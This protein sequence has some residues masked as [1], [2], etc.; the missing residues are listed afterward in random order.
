M[1]IF[2]PCMF[3]L[4]L[5]MLCTKIFIGIILGLFG[6]CFLI[7]EENIEITVVHVVL[8]ILLLPITLIFFIFLGLKYVFNNE[9]VNQLKEIFFLPC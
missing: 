5:F 6:F 1:T 9:G 2:L 4:F 7:E 8:G 3:F